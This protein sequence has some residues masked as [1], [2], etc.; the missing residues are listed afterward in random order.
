MTKEDQEKYE[1]AIDNIMQPRPQK[2]VKQRNKNMVIDFDLNPHLL[3]G[4][5][6]FMFN[7]DYKDFFFDLVE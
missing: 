4:P 7:D 3:R 2:S 5:N 6:R 1:A